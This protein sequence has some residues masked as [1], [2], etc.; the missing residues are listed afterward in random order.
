[1]LMIFCRLVAGVRP[2]AIRREGSRLC[3]HSRS[4]PRDAGA[5]SWGESGI[6]DHSK[7]LVFCQWC[8][9]RLQGAVTAVRQVAISRIVACFSILLATWAHS[10]SGAGRIPLD[11]N[12]P[13]SCRSVAHSNLL[14]TEG[15]SSGHGCSQSTWLGTGLLE[16]SF[17]QLP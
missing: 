7:C 13:E 14:R 4:A 3:R 5:C 10:F 16:A 15:R 12:V 8:L 11:R 6:G 2:R 17:Y 9:T 1:M